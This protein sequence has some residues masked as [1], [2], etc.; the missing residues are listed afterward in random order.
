MDDNHKKPATLS[1]FPAVDKNTLRLPLTAKFLAALRATIFIFILYFVWSLGMCIV[2]GDEF[3]VRAPF[4]A[5]I[6]I[7]VVSGAILVWIGIFV[8]SL[9]RSREEIALKV[10]RRIN[11]LP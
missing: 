6:W 5:I 11:S 9:R 10:L 7:L 2:A 3:V 4:E 8:N 1:Y